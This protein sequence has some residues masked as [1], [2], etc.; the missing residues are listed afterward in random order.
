MTYKKTTP[1]QGSSGTALA[2]S[3][4]QDCKR[5]LAE[6]LVEV[7]GSGT[8]DDVQV[9]ADELEQL[10]YCVLQQLWDQGTTVKAGRGSITDCRADLR[11]V[12][13]RGWPPGSTWDSVPG[14]YDSRSNSVFIATTGHGTA[15]GTRVP[16]ENEGHGAVNLVL[17]EVGHA[18]DLGSGRPQRRSLGSEFNSARNQDLAGLSPYETQRDQAT[19]RPGQEETYAESFARFYSNDPND[20]KDHP[21]LHAYWAANPSCSDN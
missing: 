11:G 13:P 3:A 10:P 12:T 7:C 16:L 21:A 5:A 19:D 2:G 20:V 1:P 9:V 14:M 15:D 6:G 4:L 18:V 17:H 8:K